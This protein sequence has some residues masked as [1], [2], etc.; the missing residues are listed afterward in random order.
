MNIFRFLNDRILAGA[1][2]LCK[3]NLGYDVTFIPT[4]GEKNGT[5][6]MAPTTADRGTIQNGIG[7]LYSYY[8]YI[9]NRSDMDTNED[10]R[11]LSEAYSKIYPEGEN[12]DYF[13]AGVLLFT[14]SD[15]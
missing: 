14:L 12:T 15:N 4:Y 13:G 10:T 1:N 7:I 8:K 9:E 5:I 6:Y 11:Y 3:Y 2:Y